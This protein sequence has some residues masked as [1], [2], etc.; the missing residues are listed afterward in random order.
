[1]V[2]PGGDE[3]WQRHRGPRRDRHAG[4][5]P[6][7]VIADQVEVVRLLR[8]LNDLVQPRQQLLAVVHL[9]AAV[10]R[11]ACSISVGI[12]RIPCTASEPLQGKLLTY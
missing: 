7:L 11:E 5:E 1:M 9:Q 2:S 6:I 10:G 8:A 4:A 12:V 3:G